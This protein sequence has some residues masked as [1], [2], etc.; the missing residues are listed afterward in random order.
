MD[1]G[2]RQMNDS[3]Q[4]YF[5]GSYRFEPNTQLLLGPE[6]EYRL[7]PDVAGVIGTLVEHAGEPV[8]RE[9]IIDSVWDGDE[10]A[11]RLLTLNIRSLRRYLG[12]SCRNPRF[13][14][15]IPGYGYRLVAPVR[16]LVPAANGSNSLAPKP[17]Q[18][19][20]RLGF[21]QYFFELRERKVCRAALMYALA[22]WAICQIAEVVFGALGFPEWAL[23]LVVVAGVLGFPIAL[24]L[25]WTFEIT[26]SG[27]TFD[28][29]VAQKHL[30]ERALRDNRWNF[31]LLAASVFISI[32]MLLYGFDVLD[33][34]DTSLERLR[35]AESIIVTPFQATS[36]SLETKAYAF[37]LS[38]EIR[39]LLN[40]EYR[41]NVISVDA[42]TTLTG[43]RRKA[44]LLLQGSVTIAHG[45][46]QVMM[47]LVDPVDG[48]DLWS[49]MFLIPNSGTANLHYQAVRRMLRTLPIGNEETDDEPEVTI[50]KAD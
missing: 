35:D 25:A 18:P 13:I 48:Y 34:K 46:I 44:D 11:N 50:A 47:H 5:I 3:T 9:H 26:P 14:E 12:D 20:N 33:H 2:N 42:L 1:T 6:G 37:A 19:Q 36:V 32:Q 21:W 43:E 40:T 45:Q 30:G 49:D 41:L 17:G 29:P 39:H 24:I 38:E 27:L 31:A 15:T 8:P 22:V 10:N 28:M 16:P 23:P 4:N 7:S